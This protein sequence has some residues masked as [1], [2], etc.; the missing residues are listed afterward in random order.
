MGTPIAYRSLKY[1]KL[2]PGAAWVAQLVKC[3]PSAQGAGIEP[4][5]GLPAQWG[6]CFSLCL[7]LP[8]LVLYLK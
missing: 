3:L 5:V 1:L 7:P 6:A 2:R 4:C 8:P